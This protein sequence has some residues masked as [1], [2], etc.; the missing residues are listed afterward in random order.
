MLIKRR[1]SDLTPPNPDILPF[2]ESGRAEVLAKW[3]SA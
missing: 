2:V 1:I 3:K